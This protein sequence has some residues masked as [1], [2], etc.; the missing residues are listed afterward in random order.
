MTVSPKWMLAGVMCNEQLPTEHTRHELLH[1]VPRAHSF[2]VDV[3]RFLDAATQNLNTDT[4]SGGRQEPKNLIICAQR[5]ASDRGVRQA[6]L[7]TDRSR[8]R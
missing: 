6:P 7:G 1:R 3:P 8:Q 4:R 5:N 2:F